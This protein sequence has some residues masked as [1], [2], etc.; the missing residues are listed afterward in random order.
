[1]MIAVPAY[2]DGTNIKPLEAVSIKQNQKII[3]TI[4]DEYV[5]VEPKTTAASASMEAF[6]NLQKYR[7]QGKEPIDYREELTNILGERYESL[8]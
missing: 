6:H 7:K 4:M 5:D 1:M 8:S 2:Y 3:L